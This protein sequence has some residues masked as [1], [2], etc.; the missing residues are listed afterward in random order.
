MDL[1]IIPAEQGSDYQNRRE[2]RHWLAAILALAMVIGASLALVT[3]SE[4]ASPVAVPI[5]Q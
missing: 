5:S 3:A 2:T 1:N 4:V